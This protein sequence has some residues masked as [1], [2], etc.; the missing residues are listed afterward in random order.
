VKTEDKEDI[1][2]TIIANLADVER[3][4]GHKPFTEAVM[5][6]IASRTIADYWRTYYKANNGLDCHSCSKTQR[7]KCRSEDLYRE[8]PKAIQLDSFGTL[9][10]EVILFT[11]LPLCLA[12]VFAV[13][14]VIET[15]VAKPVVGYGSAGY[16]IHHGFGEGLVSVIALYIGKVRNYRVEYVLFVLS[17]HPVGEA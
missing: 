16:P 5:Y 2:H 4:N 13:Q 9:G 8:C 14:T 12:T 17:L 11:L 3:N 10:I 7:Q 6:R 15:V 1:L